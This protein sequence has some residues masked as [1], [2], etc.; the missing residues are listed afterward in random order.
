MV[1]LRQNTATFCRMS[2][3]KVTR[4]NLKLVFF[5]AL[6]PKY[7]IL[8]PKNLHMSK[9]NSNFACKIFNTYGFMRQSQYIYESKTIT[10]FDNFWDYRIIQY[11]TFW[12]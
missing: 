10:F 1:R 6:V 4:N 5:I 7:C 12:L 8:A 3:R 9:I 2:G 11:C